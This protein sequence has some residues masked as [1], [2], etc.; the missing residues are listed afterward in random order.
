MIYWCNVCDHKQVDSNKPESGKFYRVS[1]HAFTRFNRETQKAE[2][3]GGYYN[4]AFAVC[5]NCDVK[6][7]LKVIE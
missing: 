7:A 2:Y 6:N 5:P 1:G 3:G 4:V